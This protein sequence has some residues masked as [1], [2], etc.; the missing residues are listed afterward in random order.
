V[1]LG[2]ACGTLFFAWFLVPIWLAFYWKRGAVRFGM[3]LVSVAAVLL[4]CLVLT[5]ADTSSFTRQI[6]GSIDWMALKF[7]GGQ[8]MGFWS[9]YDAA[10][11]IPVFTLFV[12]M[13]V[14]L[15]IWPVQKNLEHLLAHSATT[16][17][18]TQ[19]WYP[20]EGGVYVLWYLPLAIIVMFRPRL[21]HL[22]AQPPQATATQPVVLAT[23]AALT[24]TSAATPAIAPKWSITR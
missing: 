6:I 13:L 3:A 19:F 15:T 18:A 7:D 17:V 2:L 8:G 5:S 20:Q 1:L 23:A 10:Y 9:L 22:S 12:I 16:V 24:T 14:M 4:A 21:N 11:R